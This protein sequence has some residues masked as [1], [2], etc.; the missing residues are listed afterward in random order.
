M[1]CT[2]HHK[3]NA[4]CYSAKLSNNQ[5]ITKKLIVVSDMVFKFL[6]PIHII[7]VSVLTD[8]D[9]RPC[10]YILD[11]HNLLDV[12]VW[13]NVI[14]I[15]SHKLTLTNSS[16]SNGFIHFITL[17]KIGQEQPRQD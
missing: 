10:N 17:L 11:I 6:C 15:W 3:L 4:L 14:R 5:L 12:F 13:I 1:I 7:V 9:V 16:F 8:Y 2:I